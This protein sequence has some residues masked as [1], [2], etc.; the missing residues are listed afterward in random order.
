MIVRKVVVQQE[1][2]RCLAVG[3]VRRAP[4]RSP[5]PPRR[6][7]HSSRRA[8]AQLSDRARLECLS[9]TMLTRARTGRMM[10]SIPERILVN[11]ALFGHA[12]NACTTETRHSSAQ[13]LHKLGEGRSLDSALSALPI[14]ENLLMRSELVR[15]GI[16]SPHF[17]AALVSWTMPCNQQWSGAT[18]GRSATRLKV[19]FRSSNSY[20]SPRSGQSSL[21]S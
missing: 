9:S 11:R 10:H 13:L 17:S 18:S 14:H 20:I 15:R 12:H 2:S 1:R 5:M 21:R 8:A 4:N 19:W 16:A 7:S 6:A 3:T